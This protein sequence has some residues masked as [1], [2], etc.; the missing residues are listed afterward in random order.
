MTDQYNPESEAEWDDAFP[1]YAAAH[2]AAILWAREILTTDFICLD[3]ETTGL[4]HDGEAVSIGIVAKGGRVLLNTLL[5]H[6]KPSNPLALAVHGVTWEATRGAPGIG[7]I[8]EILVELLTGK[9]VIGYNA[10][11]DHRIIQ[12]TLAR[13]GLFSIHW[14]TNDAMSAFAAFYGE[15]N[16]YRQS[17]TCKKLTFAAACFGITVAGA[18]GAVADC[19]MTM[20]VVGAMARAKCRGE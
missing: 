10:V 17:Y 3:C 8:Y 15:Y 12:Q 11:F 6:E 9:A 2:D 1:D 16:S 7:D 19:L 13:H 18:H 5:C 4:D 20:A 14:A